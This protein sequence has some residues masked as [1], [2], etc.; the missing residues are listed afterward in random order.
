MAEFARLKVLPGSPDTPQSVEVDCSGMDFGRTVQLLVN[1][2]VRASVP[3]EIAG[4]ATLIFLVSPGPIRNAL[5]DLNA[6][7]GLNTKGEASLCRIET[8]D[9]DSMALRYQP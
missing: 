8:G 9:G 1:D 3:V 6:C 2:V 7:E 5:A 4:G